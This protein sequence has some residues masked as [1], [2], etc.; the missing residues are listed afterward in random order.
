MVCLTCARSSSRFTWSLLS[1]CIEQGFCILQIRRI[2]A[3]GEPV[4]DR[5]QEVTG[6]LAFALLPPEASEADGGAYLPESALCARA[7]RRA[8]DVCWP[9]ALYPLGPIRMGAMLAVYHRERSTAPMLAD[10]AKM[11]YYY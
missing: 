5:C 3:F 4:V 11:T 6:F 10:P 2:K 9:S 1:Q 7:T 8:R